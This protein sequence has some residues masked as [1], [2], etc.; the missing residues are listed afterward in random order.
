MSLLRLDVQPFILQ[1]VSEIF[2]PENRFFLLLFR[3]NMHENVDLAAGP[4]LTEESREWKSVPP[5][6]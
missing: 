6:I 3:L 4:E 1:V 2:E 5:G